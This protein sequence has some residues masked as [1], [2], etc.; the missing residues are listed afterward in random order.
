MTRLRFGIGTR[1][2][3]GFGFMLLLML[4]LTWVSIAQV[5]ALNAD[6]TQINTVNSVKQRFAINFRGSVHD[7]AIGIRD[8]VLVSAEQRPQ[9]VATIRALAEDYALNEAAMNEM[10]NGPTGASDAERRML[11]EIAAIQARANPL[12]NQVINDQATGRIAASYEALAEVRPLFVDW[13]AAINA[14]IDYQEELNR[15][16]GAQ[17]QQAAANF[18]TLALTAL[19]GAL[20]LALGAAYV[21]SRSITAPLARLSRAM[22]E[23]A[24]GDYASAMPR[25]DSS[26]EIG[27]MAKTVN[28]FR[29]N[30]LKVAELSRLEA[31]RIAA[32]ID[33]K[34]QIDA[35]SKAQAVVEFEPDGTIITANANFCA[36][37]EYQLDE[38][39]G[40][41]HRMF[42]APEYAQSG[43]HT[44]F[45]ARLAAGEH[46]VLELQRFGKSGREVW[47]QAS[48]NPI[49]G[50]DGEVYKVVKFAI[51]VTGRKAAVNLLREGLAK[52][53]EG[54][55]T[56]RIDTAFIVELEDLRKAFNGSVE[57]F[58]H[59][60]RNL[61]STSATLRT[62]TG[63]ILSGA[64]DLSA[65][66][67]RQA[68]TI[69]QTSAIIARLAGA[70]VENAQLAEDASVVA[71]TSSVEAQDGATMM[72]ETTNAMERI[73]QSSTRVADIIGVI[74]QI[75]FQT[76]LLALN[77]SV[78]AARAGEAG[79]SFAVVAGEVRTL[80]Q[81]VARSSQEVKGLIQQ[82]S[83][84]V[85]NGT[86]LVS[87]TSATLLNLLEG[88]K[89]TAQ[90][91]QSI[92]LQNREQASAIKGVSAA[93]R[94]MEVMTQHNG[95]LVEETNA[96]IEQTEAQ[97]GD[98]DRAV[99][100]F[101]LGD[102]V[103]AVPQRR[104]T[105][106]EA[107]QNWIQGNTALDPD[108]QNF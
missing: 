56:S 7:R 9:V 43:E 38:I 50:S 99:S 36:V 28:V 106:G 71:Q 46:Q 85:K 17:V 79:K 45:W 83:Q 93:V 97:A 84:E 1:L 40:R 107:R 73:I 5:N 26:D 77:A 4:I 105:G 88:T 52:L 90:R 70:V 104:A 59:I 55:L 30:G 13:L 33:A 108:W 98:L 15:T 23:M 35:I 101:R 34:G 64:N 102:E 78:E 69:E 81:S 3:L 74:D 39:R 80:S 25:M 68:A 53:A 58:T 87:A 10:V 16:I 89:D 61:R 19:A 44:Q 29:E 32:A 63:E 100:I 21:V 76:N 12:V 51:D 18:Q 75:A 95:A 37:M 41:H 2:V 48:Y 91:L 96:A 6:L 22:R 103:I 86:R 31:D 8:V 65:R 47:I 14:F 42:C 67:S 20:I 54:D 57:R 24:K 11:D 82:S 92:A 49:F 66:T 60:V 62:A 72:A 94:E 27:D